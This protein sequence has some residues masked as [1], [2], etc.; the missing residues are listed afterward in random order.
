MILILNAGSSAV[1]KIGDHLSSLG[2]KWESRKVDEINDVLVYE[3]FV[4]SGN[5]LLFTKN[6]IDTSSYFVV[7]EKLLETKKPILGICFGHQLIG[8]HFESKIDIGER[9]KREEE[10][11]IVKENLLFEGL[12]ATFFMEEDHEEFITLPKNFELLAKST[13][14]GNEAM[15]CGNIYGV[16]FH[17]ELSN[18]GNV[19]FRNFLSFLESG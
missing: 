3:G 8:L 7:L 17:P 6:E 14:C 1:S 13:S 19:I 18:K 4:I 12:G 10:I 9:I 2:V 16:Q 15:R 5:P 11:S